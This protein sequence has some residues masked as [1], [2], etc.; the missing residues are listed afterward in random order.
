M[1]KSSRGWLGGL[2]VFLLLRV[3]EGAGLV[4]RKVQGRS[5]VCRIDARPLAQANEWLRFYERFWSGQLDALDALLK[6]EDSQTSKG[7]QDED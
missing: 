3:L 5:H 2:A 1:N 7:E 4:H 6:A